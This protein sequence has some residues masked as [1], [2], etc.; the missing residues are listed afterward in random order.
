M[1]SALRNRVYCIIVTQR[2]SGDLL[3][4]IEIADAG[5]KIEAILPDLSE[6]IDEGLVTLEKVRVTVYRHNSK[7][8]MRH[9]YSTESGDRWKI[10]S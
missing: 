5:D 1:D 3:I 4:V 2:L 7:K 9:N 8:R 6:I 10:V